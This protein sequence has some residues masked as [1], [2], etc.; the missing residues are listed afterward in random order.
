MLI[1]VSSKGIDPPQ[2]EHKNGP[3]YTS[4]VITGMINEI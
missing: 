3:L 4:T 2:Y 1:E